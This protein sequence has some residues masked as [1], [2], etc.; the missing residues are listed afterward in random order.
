MEWIRISPNKLKIMLS[1]EDARRFELD[2]TLSDQADVMTRASFREILRAVKEESGFDAKEDKVYIHMYPSKEGGCE[3][4]VTKI[5]LLLDQEKE[6][7]RSVQKGKGGAPRQRRENTFAYRF[8]DFDLLLAACRRLQAIPL[9]KSSAFR[10]EKGVWWLFLSGC[11]PQKLRFLTSYARE[12]RT[13]LARL[14]L[15]EY[16]SA[17]CEKNAVETLAKL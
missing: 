9:R 11:E 3:L 15:D 6:D 16:G 10:D 1:A 8:A 14:Y 2:C 12:V 5:G 4:F 13:D 17:V 7:A